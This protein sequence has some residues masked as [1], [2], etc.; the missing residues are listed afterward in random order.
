MYSTVFGQ[1]TTG[2][3]RVYDSIYKIQSMI[4]KLAIGLL[5]FVSLLRF[6]L[7]ETGIADTRIL[8]FCKLTPS[9]LKTV[10]L[11]FVLII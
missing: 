3:I 7:K 4:I 5:I 10:L 11:R 1:S 9:G 8:R 2:P 6:M